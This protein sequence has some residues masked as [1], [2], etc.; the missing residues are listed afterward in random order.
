M[1]CSTDESVD[2][3]GHLQKA[4]SQFWSQTA[5]EVLESGEWCWPFQWE[6]KGGNLSNCLGGV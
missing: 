6:P 4:K 1:S 2:L 5:I 3:P